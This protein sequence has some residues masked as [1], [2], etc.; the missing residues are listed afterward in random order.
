M[1]SDT[2]A[3]PPHAKAAHQHH[4]ANNEPAVGTA[5]KNKSNNNPP[6][7]ERCCEHENSKRDWL[8]IANLIVLILAFFAAVAA[9]VEADRLA[10]LT[11]DAISHADESATT[12]HLDTIKALKKAEAANQTSRQALADSEMEARVRL[13]S[14]LSIAAKRSPLVIGQPIV[15]IAVIEAGG[16]TPAFDVKGN[17]HAGP[18]PVTLKSG[19]ITID[20]PGKKA[21]A[22]SLNPGNTIELQ[23]ISNGPVNQITLDTYKNGTVTRFYMWG[24][25]AY[26]DV[27][28]CHRWQN[29]CFSVN[30]SNGSNPAEIDPCTKYNNAE[31][32]P[33]E[34]PA[35]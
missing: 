23:S 25:V 1:P 9:A 35:N 4:K 15:A 30:D 18:R 11:Q 17:G 34:C 12:Q 3:Q 29:Y 24:R 28:G 22:I 19:D 33:G 10:G 2:G 32:P 31:G 14:Y 5:P 6:N 16:Q 20:A 8:D 13:R 27:F 26:R 21:N 7:P